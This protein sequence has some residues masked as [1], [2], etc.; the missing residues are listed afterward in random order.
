MSEADCKCYAGAYKS[1]SEADKRAISLVSWRA[2]FSTLADQDNFPGINT[3]V[4]NSTGGPGGIRAMIFDTGL[5]QY[6]DAGTNRLNVQSNGGFTAVCVAKFFGVNEYESVVSFGNGPDNWNIMLQRAWNT[7]T[8]QFD[9]R[10]SRSRCTVHSPSNSL[11][12]DT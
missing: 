4:F 12:V 11:A 5:S 10:D 7:N 9:I 8:F 1:S 2:Q 6:M 3:A